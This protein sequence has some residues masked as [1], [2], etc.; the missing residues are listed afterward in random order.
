MIVFAPTIVVIFVEVGKEF[1]KER[2]QHLARLETKKH[3]TTHF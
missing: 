1:A 2:K 3:E